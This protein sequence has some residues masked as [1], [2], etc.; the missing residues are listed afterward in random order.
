MTQQYLV[1]EMSQLLGLLQGVVHG[2]AEW[3]VTRLRQEAETTDPAELGPV[4]LRAL[5][6]TDAL[7]WESLRDG[8]VTAFARQVEVAAELHE[9]AVCSGLLGH[10]RY[11]I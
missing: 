2:P 10:G 5:V 9:F 11:G 7:C 3:T 6:V 4:V 8:E 1:G